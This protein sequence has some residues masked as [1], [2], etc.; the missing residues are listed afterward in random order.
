MTDRQGPLTPKEEAALRE[1]W[2]Q[3]IDAVDP[4]YHPTGVVPRLLATLDAE[5]AARQESA[6]PSGLDLQRTIDYGTGYRDGYAK[7]LA[8]VREEAADTSGLRE[9]LDRLDTRYR[10]AVTEG[11]YDYA[12][13]IG[14][15]TA[16]VRA[17]LSVARRGSVPALDVEALARELQKEVHAGCEERTHH[18]PAR[19]HLPAAAVAAALARLSAAGGSRDV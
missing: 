10:I 16:A 6:D 7:A 4:D 8:D 2:S 14:Q 9:A 19:C 17:A 5:R 15:A 18:G 12:E 11:R 1:K 3:F 13:G